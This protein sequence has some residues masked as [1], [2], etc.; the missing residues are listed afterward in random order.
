MARNTSNVID[1]AYVQ[2]F[3]RGTDNDTAPSLSFYITSR[4]TDGPHRRSGAWVL[5]S[6]PHFF[7][8]LT[9]A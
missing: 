1:G 3:A 5:G 7:A 6:E 2:S 9:L 4:R 8:S